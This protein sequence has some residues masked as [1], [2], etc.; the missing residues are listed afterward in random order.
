M[1]IITAL[2]CWPAIHQPTCHFTH[3]VF[4]GC[5]ILHAAFFFLIIIIEF[6]HCSPSN[7]H[8]LNV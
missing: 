1:D 3:L 5:L 2:I 4:H 7:S 8:P 6:A